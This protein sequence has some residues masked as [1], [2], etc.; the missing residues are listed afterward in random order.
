MS[1][2]V[3]NWAWQLK[4]K[5][6]CKLVL[7]AL[8]DYANDDGICWP[9]QHALAEKCNMDRSTVIN[10][11]K[12]LCALDLVLKRAS[13]NEKGYRRNNQYHLNV[14]YLQSG[15]NQSWENPCR[16]N[17]SLSWNSPLSN[18]GKSNSNIIKHHI[19]TNKSSVE[20][21]AYWKEKLGHPKAKLDQKR[22][23]RISNAL[24]QY[25][26]DELKQAIDGC[27]L[28]PYHMGENEK[29]I[30]YDDIELILRDAKHIEQFINIYVRHAQTSSCLETEIMGV[31]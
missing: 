14:E 9:S 24:K 12:T 26:I 21:F 2:K 19:T 15:E 6:G 29:K 25:S 10:H 27:A 1:I 5:P 22:K 23:S 3:S 13:N 17:S 20:I 28:S 30:R 18:V 8:A 16:E 31:E 4:L 11:I 7:L